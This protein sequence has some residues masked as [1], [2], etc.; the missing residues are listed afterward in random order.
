MH[1]HVSCDVVINSTA[2]TDRSYIH[3]IVCEVQNDP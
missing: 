3:L 1:K 2:D